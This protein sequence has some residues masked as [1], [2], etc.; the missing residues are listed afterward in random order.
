[1]SSHPSLAVFAPNLLAGQSALV[2]GG[3]SGIGAGIAEALAAHGAAVTLV[4]RTADKLEAVAAKIKAAGGRAQ[5]AAAD[6]REGAAVEAAVGKAVA[7]HGGL[8]LVINAAAGNFLV[9][10]AQLSPNGFR[11]VIDIDLCGTF[12]T[13]RYAYAHLAAR[14][15]SVISIT[16]MQAFVATPL[17]CHVG[18]AKAGIE[19]L[20]RDLALEWG[21]SG[22]RVNTIAPGPID[23]T[24][25]MRRLAP[26][27]L[28]DKMM[29]SLPLKR[30]GTIEEIAS[31]ALFLASPAGRWI[32]GASFVVDGGSVLIG[33]GRFL[34]FL[35]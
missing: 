30:W 29:A 31:M 18:A 15:G 11:S 16:A 12:N 8:D 4:G 33:P 23:E 26:G 7:E 22:V 32:T 9:P 24:E 2:T 20:T 5:A 3:G 1:M 27:D 14:K 28:R 10:A 34:D 13:C 6:V 25:G 21:A 35:G 19:K 17:Q